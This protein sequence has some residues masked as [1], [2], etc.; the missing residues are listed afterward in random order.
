M[1]GKSC[2]AIFSVNGSSQSLNVTAGKTL[3]D[4][5][6]RDGGGSSFSLI[7]LLSDGVCFLSAGRKG[8]F[9]FLLVEAD[10]CSSPLS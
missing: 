4:R 3:S 1:F 5:S 6:E 10:V 8:D 2:S 7:I 9:C